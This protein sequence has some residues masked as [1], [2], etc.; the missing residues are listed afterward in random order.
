ME[1]A[2]AHRKRRFRFEKNVEPARFGLH[3]LGRRVS[4]GKNR[5][6]NSIAVDG[7]AEID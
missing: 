3:N 4:F 5:E 6:S 2:G 7:E 1:N